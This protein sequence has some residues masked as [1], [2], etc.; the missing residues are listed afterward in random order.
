MSAGTSTKAMPHSE[1]C[2]T[3]NHNARI[4]RSRSIPGKPVKSKANIALN[5]KQNRNGGQVCRVTKVPREASDA[6]ANVYVSYI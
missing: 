5:K 3:S 6:R 2:R 1:L 4:P